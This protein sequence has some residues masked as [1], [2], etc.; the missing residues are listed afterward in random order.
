M[1]ERH[2]MKRICSKILNKN[3]KI[4]F[5]GVVNPSGKLL[6]GASKHCFRDSSLQSRISKFPCWYE[7]FTFIKNCDLK[8]I[9]YPSEV[10]C[11][12]L[13]SSTSILVILPLNYEKDKFVVFLLNNKEKQDLEPSIEEILY[14]I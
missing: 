10:L 11:V 5:V 6:T 3:N 14:E 7:I 8:D 12:T 13:E 2:V 9:S 4:I 1:Y